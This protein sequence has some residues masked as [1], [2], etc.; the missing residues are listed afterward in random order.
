MKNL[1]IYADPELYWVKMQV[2][3]DWCRGTGLD[4][5]WECHACGMTMIVPEP[6][7]SCVHPPDSLHDKRITCNKCNGTGRVE[8]TV[9][10][11][12]F[13]EVLRYKLKMGGET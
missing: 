9:K 11:S 1:T 5:Y 12:Q 7:A 8:M 6:T 13:I 2:E 3:C 4:G 10:L